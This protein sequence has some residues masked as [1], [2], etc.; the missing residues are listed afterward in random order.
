MFLTFDFDVISDLQENC[1]NT[2]LYVFF[3]WYTSSD[4]CMLK[5]VKIPLNPSSRIPS[6]NIL[7][8]L[9]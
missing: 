9:P 5:T 2:V 6:V 4:R 8:N 3:M 7:P 1:K